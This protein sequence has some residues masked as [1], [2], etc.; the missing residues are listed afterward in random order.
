MSLE[1]RRARR[2]ELDVALNWAA[3]EGWNPGL[4]DAGCFWAADPG[5]F[6][7]GLHD[8]EPAAFI[9]AVRYA[10]GFGFLGF[11]LV[12]PDLRGRG[13][14][15]AVWAAGV[16]HLA[17]RNVGLDGVV[18]QQD[19]YRRSGFTLAYRNVRYEGTGAT[20]SPVTGTLTPLS[21]VPFSLLAAYD[22][23]LFQAPRQAFLE[24]W[25]A[26]P[27]S[28]A[29]GKLVGGELVGYG[30]LRRCRVGFKAGPLFADN[31][32]V[33]DEL[34]VAM[35]SFAGEGTPVLLDIPEVNRAAVSLAERHGMRPVFET[36]RM[37]NHQ[38]PAIPLER[39]FGVTTFELG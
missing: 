5:G 28:L 15:L 38:P 10:D 16:Q 39:I 9:S 34:F 8:D 20:P 3:A 37:Y 19:N 4:N 1:L 21:E 26:Q 30:V 12:R 17:G 11:Y 23:R 32:D 14:G 25:V 31:G 22:R 35:R 24:R 27:G 2:E 6:F 7:V 13:Y 36:A 29:V 33:A 18:E